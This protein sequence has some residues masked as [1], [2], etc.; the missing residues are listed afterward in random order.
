MTP[1]LIA[2]AGGL[3]AA[4]RFVVDGAV[5]HRNPFR[6][7]LG[8]LVI[9]VSGSLLLGLLTG[10]VL[11]HG[12]SSEVKLILGTGFLGGYTTF[13]TASVEAVRLA[14]GTRS[15]A[16]AFA[17]A[18]GMLVLSLAAAGLGLWLTTP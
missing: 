6:F 12:G 11:A 9:N 18:T 15:L 7:P 5:A 10:A 14:A 17:H 2:L 8:T 16:L 4:S 3:G 13:S 1:L